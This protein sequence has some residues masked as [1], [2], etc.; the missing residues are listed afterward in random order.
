VIMPFLVDGIFDTSEFGCIFLLWLIH[1]K[2]QLML[3]KQSLHAC[4]VLRVSY[5]RLIGSKS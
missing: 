4:G 5:I 2:F 1:G 3:L